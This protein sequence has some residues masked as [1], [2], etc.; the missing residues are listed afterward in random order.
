MSSSNDS[1]G[2][3][4]RKKDS[5]L[6]VGTEVLHALFENGKSELSRQFIRWKLWA[7]WAEFVGAQI[8]K[9]SEPVG[10]KNGTLYVWVRNSSWMQQM[11]FILDPMKEQINTRL[12][13]QY[14]KTIVLT[15]DKKS[16]PR[17][18][19]QSEEIK[20]ELLGFFDRSTN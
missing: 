18:A 4:N 20:N 9:N 8:G 6:T 19:Q 16:V 3:F 5:D 11:I 13:M 10:Y 2:N 17:E 7:K 15:L 12:E 14:V 1:N